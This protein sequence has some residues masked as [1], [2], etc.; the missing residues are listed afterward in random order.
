MTGRPKPTALRLIEGNPSRR[1]FNKNE[2]K[3]APV[4][5][6]CPC[7]LNDAAKIE[8]KR[9]AKKLPKLGLLTVIDGPQFALYRQAWGRWVEAEDALKKHGTI[10]K[11]L[12]T[13]WPMQSPYLA[14]AN[15]AM[16]QMQRAL[17]EFG[18]SPAS[19]TRVLGADISAEDDGSDLLTQ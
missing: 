15:K 6:K 13:G 2:P 8:W 14:V 5:P 11:A 4:I 19:R 9:T 18:M 17:S 10:V 16:E 7:H 1:P 12:K 3:P